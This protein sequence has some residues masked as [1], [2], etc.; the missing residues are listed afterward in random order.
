M[1]LIIISAI[2][3]F[4]KDIIALLKKN[5]I[6]SFSY[7][8]VTGYHDVSDLN[9]ESNWFA[10]EMNQTESILFYAFAK[11]ETINRLMES[12]TSFNEDQESNSH[13]HFGVVALE[14]FNN[15]TIN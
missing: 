5:Q 14:K 7:K 6:G 4:K 8:E 11:T 3:E 2:E 1:K 15:P 13:I 10:N 12:I 9:I